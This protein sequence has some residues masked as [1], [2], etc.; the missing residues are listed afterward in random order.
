MFDLAWIAHSANFWLICTLQWLLALGVAIWRRSPAPTGRILCLSMAAGI[1][2]SAAYDLILGRQGVF[3]Y[4]GS[5]GTNLI[6]G[7]G[8][9]PVHLLANGA[10]SYGAAFATVFY[11]RGP[12]SDIARPCG[13][14]L[15]AALI[16]TIALAIAG[17]CLSPPGSIWLMFCAGIAILGAGE[18][19]CLLRGRPGPIVPLLTGR[20]WR[21]AGR[22]WLASLLIGSAYELANLVFPFWIWL[23]R[24]GLPPMVV[25]CLVVGSGYVVLLHPMVVFWDSMGLTKSDKPPGELSADE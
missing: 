24:G 8:L 9:T 22:L 15:H 18:L 17:D 12:R 14:L 19:I 25:E 10:I 20:D 5:M 4:G 16:A 7:V 6:P 2:F 21:P 23:P 3:V 1:V 13:R 11:L